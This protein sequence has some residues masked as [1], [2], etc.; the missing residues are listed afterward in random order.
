MKFIFPQ[1][2]KFNKKILGL[3][4][5]QTAILNIIWGGIVFLIVNFIFNSL[6]LKIFLFIILVFPILVFSV[7]GINGENVIN[8]ITYIFKFIIRPKIFLYNK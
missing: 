8:V 4:D 7:V 6:N 1:N 3:I 2:Y 5:Y